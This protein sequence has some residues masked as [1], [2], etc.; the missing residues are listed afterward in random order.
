MIATNSV[1][2]A[3]EIL[4]R[5]FNWAKRRDKTHVGNIRL[6]EIAA[7]IEGMRGPVDPTLVMSVEFQDDAGFDSFMDAMEEGDLDE[8][9]FA[10]LT[11]G[12]AKRGRQ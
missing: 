4:I 2:P 8:F 11:L 1:T 3:Q 5:M 6:S 10:S 9:R 7:A 12:A